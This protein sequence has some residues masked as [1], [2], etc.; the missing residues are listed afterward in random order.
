ML[1]NTASIL[2]GLVV[3]TS[4]AGCLPFAPA[5]PASA[6]PTPATT[7]VPATMPV[8]ALPTPSPG[9]VGTAPTLD[10]GTVTTTGTEAPGSACVENVA[11]T[12]DVTIPDGTKLRPA[13]TFVKTWR[14]KNNGT[15]P[16]T[17]GYAMVFAKGDSLGAPL[18]VPFPA[19][20]AP[21]A[22]IDVSVKMTA[23]VTPGTYRGNWQIRD[24]TGTVFGITNTNDRTFWVQIV[25]AN[26]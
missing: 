9:A 6:L 1:R 16:W 4:L 26:K 11:M 17:T 18:Q 15:C 21:G 3:V 14:L 19:A 2:I 10:S 24:T 25:V 8:S 7:F 20:V 22:S 5:P 12:K 23:P 13:Q